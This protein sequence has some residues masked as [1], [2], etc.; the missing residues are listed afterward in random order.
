MLTREDCL[1]LDRRDPLAAMREQFEPVEPGWIYLDANSI[2]AMP[3]AAPERV[4]RTMRSQWHAERAHAWGTARWSDMARRIG[5]GFAKLLGAKPEELTSADNTTVNLYKL[6]RYSLQL[7]S[8]DARRKYIVYE[9]ESFPTDCHVIEGVARHSGGRWLLR[10][11]DAPE[12]LGAA[13]DDEVAVVLLTHA[14]YRTSY[15]WNLRDTTAR[16]HAV[17][18]RVIWDLSHSAGAVPIDLNASRADFAVACT[19]KYLCGGPG[20]TALAYIRQDLQDRDWPAIPGWQGRKDPTAFISQY[21]PHPGMRSM[22]TGTGAVLQNVVTET[23]AEI[24][25]TVDRDAVPAKHRELSR[26]LITLLEE[27]CAS[28]GVELIS[29]RDWEFQGGAVA[30]RCPDGA[31]ACEALYQ[32]RVVCTFRNPDSLRFGLSPATLRYVELWDAVDR[33]KQILTADQTASLPTT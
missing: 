20:A 2:G 13:L 8:S 16:I 21:E 9:R 4:L 18:A 3:K 10:P 6:L 15:R 24:W 29:P 11:V 19:Y 17:G 12:A 14:D 1:E 26:V 22:L 27:R 23:A 31:A 32:R 33:L 28:L 7:A 25:A 5:A 30:F